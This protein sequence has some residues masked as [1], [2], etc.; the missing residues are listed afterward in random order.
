MNKSFIAYDH[1]QLL[2]PSYL[3]ENASDEIKSFVYFYFNKLIFLMAAKDEEEAKIIKEQ[4]S[5]NLEF[6]LLEVL[7]IGLDNLQSVG[8][9]FIYSREK[10][11][12]NNRINKKYHDFL[13]SINSNKFEP[14]AALLKDKLPLELE[15][16]E[17][18]F[19]ITNFANWYSQSTFYRLDSHTQIKPDNTNKG[20]FTS[21]AN[22]ISKWHHIPKNCDQKVRP[23]GIELS[24]EEYIEF[25]NR[26]YDETASLIEANKYN[27]V[28][29]IALPITS[30][31]GDEESKPI[32]NV[33]LHLGLK[34]A[35]TEIQIICFVNFFILTWMKKYWKDITTNIPKSISFFPEEFDPAFY[36]IE[37]DKITNN[38]AFQNHTYNDFLSSYFKYQHQSNKYFFPQAISRETEEILQ[39]LFYVKANKKELAGS[40]FQENLLNN[41]ITAQRFANAQ[42]DQYEI[43]EAMVSIHL[44]I[45]AAI[46]V[47][48]LPFYFTKN[49]TSN[50][51]PDNLMFLT[52]NELDIDN[53]IDASTFEEA[54]KT[55]IQKNRLIY[56]GH[57]SPNKLEKIKA[58]IKKSMSPFE[59]KLFKYCV[60]HLKKLLE[61]NTEEKEKKILQDAIR[62][63]TDLDK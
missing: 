33:F 57:H 16:N 54:T 39:G 29:T 62:N 2:V 58:N 60:A 6:A 59:K 8:D 45:K 10:E 52:P 61:H 36:S 41:H 20:G 56:C 18:G 48:D 30:F 26:Y 9:T 38:K 44:I 51:T 32:G 22:K 3:L 31:D 50:S 55:Y 1:F 53:K 4:D 23:N 34:R 24:E 42:L 12:I 27:Y 37:L 63:I 21:R 43:T 46:I 49:L 13:N 15:N 28:L 40:N 11:D 47:Y 35:P 5:K 14:I 19:L 25:L 7:T 17:T